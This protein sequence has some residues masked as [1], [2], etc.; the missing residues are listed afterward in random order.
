M[1]ESTCVEGGNLV[2]RM[3]CL[4][5]CWLGLGLGCEISCVVIYTADLT[6]EW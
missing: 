4:C 3:V 1:V 5:S 6:G 2:Q